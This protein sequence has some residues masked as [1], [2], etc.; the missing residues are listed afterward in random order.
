LYKTRVKSLAVAVLVFVSL[1]QTVYATEVTFDYFNGFWRS[2]T[3]RTC[4][5]I[6]NKCEWA[7]SDSGTQWI[8]LLTAYSPSQTWRPVYIDVDIDGFKYY[9][10]V[11]GGWPSFAQVGVWAYIY[12]V[13][14]GEMIAATGWIYKVRIESSY[15]EGDLS[16]RT[17]SNNQWY[18]EW[19][20]EN[21]QPYELESGKSYY[22]YIEVQ[23]AVS[24]G[25]SYSDIPWAPKRGLGIDWFK[26][27][28]A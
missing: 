20:V 19:D 7:Y 17:W 9:L 22:I 25:L 28:T 1:I 15:V 26:L 24:G 21:G 18:W 11:T 12:R 23:H 27:K 16:P 8:A 5:D 13:D 6:Y 14:T 10:E 2:T 4:A 3:Y